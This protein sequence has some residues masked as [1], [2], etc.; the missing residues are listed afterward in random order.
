MEQTWES[1]FTEQAKI[2]GHSQ[3][4]ISECLAYAGILQS[5]NVPVIFDKWHFF[6]FFPD[7]K[8]GRMEMFLL[9]IGCYKN[10]SIR[11]K[12]GGIRMISAP[13]S[14]LK[15]VQRW[16]YE[17][18]LLKD[19]SSVSPCAEG[20]IPKNKDDI[21]NIVTN[22][23]RHARSK[24]LIN[25]DIQNF[26]DSI[27]YD[28][29]WEYFSKYG[30][31]EEVVDVLAKICTYQYRL[32]QGAPTSPMLSNLIVRS[33]DD[34]FVELA[35]K[36]NCIYSR[37][38]DDI[39]LSGNSGSIM[40]SMHDIYQIFYAH[41]FRPNKKK[42]KISFSCDRQMVTGLTITDGVHVPKKYR[43]DVRKELYCC[44]KFGAVSHIAYRHPDQGMYRYWLLGRIMFIKSE[45]PS[46]DKKCFRNLIR[47]IGAYNVF[48]ESY[49]STQVIFSSNGSIDWDYHNI[50]M[51]RLRQKSVC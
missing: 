19:L 27:K 24:W 47:L 43:K 15:R 29:V 25:V 8:N 45:S 26:F 20:F 46:V 41:H 38:A 6:S 35:C 13:Y 18:I 50:K 11:K 1:L 44:K 16:V 39:T 17:N 12:T 37:Y 31:E 48:F 36:C 22:A 49:L 5:H 2:E 34:A 4:Y 7:I 21:R 14:D 40:P 9:N 23:R 51:A 33:M 42:T 30:Y 28:S 3:Q 32:P 10:Y